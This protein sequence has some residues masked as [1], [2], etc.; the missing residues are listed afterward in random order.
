[1]TGL[2]ANNPSHVQEPSPRDHAA[3]LSLTRP[4]RLGS[5]PAQG[6]SHGILAADEMIYHVGSMTSAT[7][8]GPM[9]RVNNAA[10]NP[11]LLFGPHNEDH[12]RVWFGSGSA[13]LILGFAEF[14]RREV[15]GVRCG[16]Y[17]HGT[18]TAAATPRPWATLDPAQAT[19]VTEIR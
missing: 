17:V 5:A 7:T 1:M 3:S 18:G 11:R 15:N 12:E 19:D 8:A 2:T 4:A 16:I 13:A 6:E 14:C 10:T 9:G